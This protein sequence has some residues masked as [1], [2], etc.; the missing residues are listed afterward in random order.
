MGS[1]PFSHLIHCFTSRGALLGTLL[2]A[3]Q[4]LA[5]ALVSTH[6]NAAV[7]LPNF[8]D[9]VEANA[10]AI[11]EISARRTVTPR[12]QLSD[13]NLEELLRG[14]RP[15]EIPDIQRQDRAPRQ[16]GA[17]G[18]GFLISADGFVITN[19]HVV[20]GADQI[21]VTLNDRRV[22]DAEVVGLDEPSDIA[23]LKLDAADLPF[24]EFGDSEAV[25]VGDWV[26]A[27]G[28]PFGLEFSAAAGIV[29]AKGRSVPGNSA[30]NYMAFIQTDVAIN[31]GNSGGP[32]FNLEGD[33]VGINSQILS[34][35]G[36]SNGISFSIPS[37]V[38]MNVVAQLK[39]SGAVERGLLG[40][41]MRE[42]DYALAEIF[43][44][45]R[46][47]GAFVDGVID[48]S[49]AG[50]AGVQD[51]DIIVEFNG[52]EIE[53]Y[54]DLPFYVGQYQPGT[55]AAVR[56]I[57]DGEERRLTVV[58]G[59]SPTN[60]ASIVVE[61]TAPERANPLGFKIS[62]LSEE[63]RQ[64]AGIDGVRIAQVEEGPGREAG[65][66]EGDVVVS[67]N[68]QPVPSVS[69]FASVAESLPA[70][71]FVQIRIVRQGQGTTLSLELKP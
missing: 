59:S 13:E 63:T 71:G 14:L 67:L 56:L 60:E 55:E 54:T 19:N 25:R 48:E 40:V 20:E 38:A 2:I 47:R 36:G 8:A 18:S 49:P 29:S 33:V 21:Q 30:Y 66:R 31:Q 58:L 6:V 34:S 57:R 10:S 26:L 46:P 4:L 12:P 41:R 69:D 27:I 28:S 42:V 22:F 44:M 9:L 5:P 52:H 70:S 11:V 65:L 35:T 3:S 17:V 51:E 15:D 16:R 43:D 62:E 53:Y 23:L 50:N 39:E 61:D 68:R 1:K 24:V 45:D 32:L 7:D 37:N 64:V